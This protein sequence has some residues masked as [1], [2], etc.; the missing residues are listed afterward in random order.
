MELNSLRAIA[1]EF[2]LEL[3]EDA[4]HAVGARFEGTPIGAGTNFTAF[5]FY[6]TKNLTTG[7]GGML[8]GSQDLLDRARVVSLHGMNREAW[9]RYAAGG[10]W[11][12]DIVE[13]GFKYNMSD[14]QAALGIHQLASLES[15][16]RRREVIWAR[17]VFAFIFMLAV[18]LPRSGRAVLS[19]KLCQCTP[20]LIRTTNGGF[21]DRCFTN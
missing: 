2:R 13:P 17:Y 9:S 5:S 18:F 6:A 20:G 7:E 4:A 14:L 11:A 15:R 8:T 12:Y 21:G 3:I 19:V 1:D 16:L 10:K